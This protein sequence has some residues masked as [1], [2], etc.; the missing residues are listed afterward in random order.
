MR[1]APLTQRVTRP[2]NKVKHNINFI[3]VIVIKLIY[4]DAPPVA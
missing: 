3:N 2:L 4:R 1:R